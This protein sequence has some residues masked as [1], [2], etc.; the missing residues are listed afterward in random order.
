MRITTR[1]VSAAAVGSATLLALGACSTATDPAPIVPGSTTKVEQTM[2]PSPSAEAPFNVRTAEES[3]WAVYS[4]GYVSSD[5]LQGAGEQ[6]IFDT[7]PDLWAQGVRALSN[8]MMAGY[9]LM[10]PAVPGALV[11]YIDGE[12]FEG[13]VSMPLGFRG[14]TTSPNELPSDAVANRIS[15]V[16]TGEW[17]AGNAGQGG[18]TI[19]ILENSGIERRAGSDITQANDTQLIVYQFDKGDRMK[20]MGEIMRFADWQTA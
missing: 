3:D 4:D 5:V 13:T 19:Q 8:K 10:D 18:Y 20:Q 1:M 6:L 17:P 14:Q 2:S 12:R 7:Y 9:N 15:A 16:T 11:Q